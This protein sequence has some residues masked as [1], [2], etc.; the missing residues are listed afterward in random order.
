MAGRSHSALPG[1][2]VTFYQDKRC[3]L[4]IFS[5]LHQMKNF[6]QLW[7]SSFS[8]MDLLFV[9]KESYFLLLFVIRGLCLTTLHIDSQLELH[10]KAVYPS[11]GKG[12]TIMVE[13]ACIAVFTLL[14]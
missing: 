2:E 14:C 6:I 11:S 13:L 9:L 4:L 12:G 10:A 7:E 5:V 8:L 1:R 3:D